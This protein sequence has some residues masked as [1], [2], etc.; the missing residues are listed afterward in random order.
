MTRALCWDATCTG[1]T[2]SLIQAQTGLE[3][4]LHISHVDYWFF[5][6]AV[7]FSLTRH[8]QAISVLTL[9]MNKQHSGFAG[10]MKSFS[11]WLL[12]KHPP[13]LGLL[14]GFLKYISAKSFGLAKL[15]FS[16]SALDFVPRISDSLDK[17]LVKSSSK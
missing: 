9:T 16:P 10:Q 5:W 2:A 7:E 8:L 12:L 3:P 17:L 13:L 4:G 15:E 14:A 6:A 1:V 11:L